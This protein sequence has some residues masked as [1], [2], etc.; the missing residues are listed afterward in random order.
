LLKDAESNAP[1]AQDTA[2]DSRGDK[3]YFACKVIR[4]LIAWRGSIN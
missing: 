3:Q 4:T 1:T 2:S